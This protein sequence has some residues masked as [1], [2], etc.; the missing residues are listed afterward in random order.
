[1]FEVEFFLREIIFDKMIEI[2]VNSNE[3]G[4][5]YVVEVIVI[6]EKNELNVNIKVIFV[7]L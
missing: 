1:M 3:Y 4:K 7:C 2:I 5:V 6:S